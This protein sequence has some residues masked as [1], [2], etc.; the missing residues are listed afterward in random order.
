METTQDQAAPVKES[1]RVKLP[2]EAAPASSAEAEPK[3]AVKRGLDPELAV[4][5]DITRKIDA[6]NTDSQARV[7]SYV[8]TRYAGP[9]H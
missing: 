4:I 7:V 1:P 2:K 3:K 9:K 5:R 8:M 6:L